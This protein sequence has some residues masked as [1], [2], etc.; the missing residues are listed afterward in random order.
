M[1]HS[2]EITQNNDFTQYLYLVN[3]FINYLIE[4]LINIYKL[5]ETIN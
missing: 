1:Y 3:D 5:I 4:Y 2:M